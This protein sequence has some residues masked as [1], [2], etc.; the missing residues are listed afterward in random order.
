[1]LQFL[2]ISSSVERVLVET[3]SPSP[4]PDLKEWISLRFQLLVKLGLVCFHQKQSQFIM[5]KTPEWISNR[6]I[7]YA[8]RLT[9]TSYV[10]GRDL[11]G[12]A[13]IVIVS[14]CIGKRLFWNFMVDFKVQLTLQQHNCCNSK[15]RA[16]FHE[17]FDHRI[18]IY[19]FILFTISII[20]QHLIFLHRRFLLFFL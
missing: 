4:G 11:C 10:S 20:K 9:L 17:R 18:N 8:V 3:S 6:W 16:F 12:A 15:I 5:W 2:Y 14:C 7:L 13:T 1:M 19:I